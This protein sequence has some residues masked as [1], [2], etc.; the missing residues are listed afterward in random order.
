MDVR[1]ERSAKNEALLREVN[2]RIDEVGERLQ[3][4][5]E[6]EVLEFRCE[7]GRPECESTVSMPPADYRRM[8][9]D[10]D[11]FVL[12]PGHE[13]LEIERV[14]ERADRYFIVDK[15]PE[16]EP[17]VGADGKPDSGA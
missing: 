5:P 2:E 4:L 6:D 14:V 13:D 9:S 17:Y 1:Q 12:V 16:A 11:R 3:V 10:N 15:R 7:C 8:R